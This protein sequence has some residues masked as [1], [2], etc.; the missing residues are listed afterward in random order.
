LRK[1]TK[2]TG[3]YILELHIKGEEPYLSV[4][5]VGRWSGGLV[6]KIWIVTQLPKKEIQ[7]WFREDVKGDADVEELLVSAGYDTYG[8]WYKYPNEIELT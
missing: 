6:A 3:S 5:Y 1:N 7:A 8:K 2:N 4:L